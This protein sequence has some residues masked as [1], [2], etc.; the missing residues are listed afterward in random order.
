M[1]EDL[2]LEGKAPLSEAAP[3]RQV[4]VRKTNRGGFS[5]RAG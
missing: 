5:F 1:N 2:I 3:E 4:V